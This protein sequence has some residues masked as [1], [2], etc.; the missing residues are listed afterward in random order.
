MGI[1]TALFSWQEFYFY[2]DDWQSVCCL[3]YSS[4]IGQ[5][6][7]YITSNAANLVLSAPMICLYQGL[8]PI[9]TPFLMLLRLC[10]FPDNHDMCV[11]PTTQILIA[12]FLVTL[13]LSLFAS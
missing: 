12:A 5:F 2:W 13:G 1:G 4:F 8:Q 9:G 11:I 3:F 6:F 7:L 10:F